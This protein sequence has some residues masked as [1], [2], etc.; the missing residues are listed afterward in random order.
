MTPNGKPALGEIIQSLEVAISSVPVAELP[1]LLGLL[2]KAKAMSWTRILAE[3]Q[4][5]QQETTGKNAMAAQDVALILNVKTSMVYE[6]VRTNRLKAYKVGKY[7]R[8]KESAIQDFLA[9]GGA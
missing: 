7:I 1:G 8:F 4:H 2:E 5:A 9:H 6:L 3:Q